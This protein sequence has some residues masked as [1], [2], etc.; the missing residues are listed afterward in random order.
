MARA[1]TETLYVRI[2]TQLMNMLRQ[3]AQACGVPLSVLTAHVIGR[4]YGTP[5]LTQAIDYARPNTK[6]V[7]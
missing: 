5:T 1:K 2:D 6:N 3:H 4:Y 7:Y